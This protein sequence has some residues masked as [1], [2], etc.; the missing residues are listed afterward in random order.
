MPQTVVNLQDEV[1]RIQV[2]LQ[3]ENQDRDWLGSHK[4]ALSDLL[5]I[6]L[7][8]IDPDDLHS[9][10]GLEHLREQLRKDL[11]QG[12]ETDKIQSVLV[13]ELLTQSR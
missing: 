5:P 12:M 3:V 1:V 7:T 8:K 9:E 4:R 11:N 2:T 6:A 13:N 10:Q